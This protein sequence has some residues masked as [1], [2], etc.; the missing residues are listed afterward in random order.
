VLLPTDIPTD[1]ERAAV[2]AALPWSDN[3]FKLAGIVRGSLDNQAVDLLEGALGPPHARAAL[4][5]LYEGCDVLLQA[6]IDLADAMTARS[7]LGR[8]DPHDPL[9][10]DDARLNPPS[11]E[12]LRL[13]AARFGIE[14]AAVK[15]ASAG[16]H[17]V[18]AHL[19]I[20]WET[21]AA[22]REEMLACKFDPSEE[23]PLFWASC[24]DLRKGLRGIRKNPLNTFTSFVLTPTF[25]RFFGTHAVGQTRRFRNQVVHRE[26][27]SYAEVAMFGRATRWQGGRWQFNFPPPANQ[28][29][30]TI[31][32]RFQMV[33]DAAA[34]TL[35]YAETTWDVA[36][37]WMRS[38]DAWVTPGDGE[39]RVQTGIGRIQPREQRDPGPFLVTA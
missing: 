37:R 7:V 16:D 30:P 2:Q 18:N 20:A 8:I 28:P 3:A 14:D 6:G 19:R 21:N 36:R 13:R 35:I 33:S 9:G 11:K 15:V 38:L 5:A 29:Q 31:E 12:R 24:D 10:G 26:R 23:T 22:T 32:E 17:L 34:A 27:P 39:V 25:R 1:E 4:V